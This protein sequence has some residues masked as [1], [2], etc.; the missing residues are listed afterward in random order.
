MATLKSVLIIVALLTELFTVQT[1]KTATEEALEE[2]LLWGLWHLVRLEQF[3]HHLAHELRAV[4]EEGTGTR[5]VSVSDTL[6]GLYVCL[7]KSLHRV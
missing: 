6:L 2:A 5:T 3:A 1:A 7:T 4:V